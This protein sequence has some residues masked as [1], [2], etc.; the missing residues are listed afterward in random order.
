MAVA[1][2]PADFQALLESATGQSELT[3]IDAGVEAEA[4]GQSFLILTPEGFRAR[5]GLDPPDPR[6]GLLLRGFRD[7][8]LGPRPG[9]GYAGSAAKRH[10]DRIVVPPSPG[11]G[12]VVAFR[13]VASEWLSRMPCEGR[14]GRAS[15]TICRSR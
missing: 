1:E 8:G 14:P 10:E 3:T 13:R 4:D 2:N 15:A 12:A 5:Y 7:D 11:L 6:R 9:G